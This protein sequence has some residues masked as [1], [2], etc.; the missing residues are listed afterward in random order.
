M[1]LNFIHLLS[2]AKIIIRPLDQCSS[3]YLL[4]FFPTEYFSSGGEEGKEKPVE[5]KLEWNQGSGEIYSDSLVWN[6]HSVRVTFNHLWSKS[7]SSLMIWGKKP[8]ANASHGSHLKEDLRTHFLGSLK[9]AGAT[10]KCGWAKMSQCWEVEGLW[11]SWSAKG[12]CWCWLLTLSD[13]IEP[14][15]FS[16]TSHSPSY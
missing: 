9:F 15:L 7:D 5:N 10:L 12:F 13:F 2:Q 8:Q 6:S 1:F 11:C 16:Q 14:G 3:S 4:L